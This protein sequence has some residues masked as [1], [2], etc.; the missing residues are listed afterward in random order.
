MTI[1]NFPTQQNLHTQLSLFN[2]HRLMPDFIQNNWVSKLQ[3]DTQ[4]L[5]VEGEYVESQ[6]SLVQDYL[7]DLPTEANAF[8]RWFEDLKIHGPGQG[9]A[10]FLW[11]SEEATMEEM[12]WFL[13]QEAA[14]E[15]G[16]DDLV[17]LTQVKF[18]E[19][20]KL[21]LARNYWDEMGRGHEQAMHGPMLHAVITDLALEPTV[22]NTVWESLALSNLMLAM[23]LNRRY[24]YQSIGA[25]GAVEMTAPT[26][27]GLVN[28]GMERLNVPFKARK[29]F[30]LHATLDVK[31][32]EEWNKEVIYSLVAA[33]PETAKP[34]AEGA[35]MRLKCGERAFKRYK[36]YFGLAAK[37]GLLN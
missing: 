30:Q 24:A 11:L 12:C 13:T 2:Q 37:D 34:I 7:V 36:Q 22:E 27:V 35:L 26:R 4:F 19:R 28:K 9:D 20:A 25:L 15:A 17:A 5:V 18:P 8:I 1:S 32:S 10:L 16:F 21:E 14:G 29:Y 23:A 31:H 3:H 6:R 33:N